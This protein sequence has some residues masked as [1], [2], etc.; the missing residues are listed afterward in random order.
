MARMS[1]LA[2]LAIIVDLLGRQFPGQKRIPFS[3]GNPSRNLPFLGKAS[4]E[5]SIPG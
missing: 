3:F 4:D 2:L 1:Y 5:I